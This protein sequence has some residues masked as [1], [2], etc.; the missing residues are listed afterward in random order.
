L[1]SAGKKKLQNFQNNFKAIV[2]FLE[3]GFRQHGHLFYQIGFVN[4]GDL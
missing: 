2:Y 3:C 4:S 1:S